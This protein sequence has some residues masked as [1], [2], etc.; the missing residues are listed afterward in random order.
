MNRLSLLLT[1]STMFLHL[2]W[3]E[4]FL[5]IFSHRQVFSN[6]CSAYRHSSSLTYCQDRVLFIC[7]SLRKYAV[8]KTLFFDH[9]LYLAGKHTDRWDWTCSYTHVRAP[10]MTAVSKK[11]DA[12]QERKVVSI[13]SAIPWCSCWQH[14]FSDFQSDKWWMT[15]TESNKTEFGLS[16][17]SVSAVEKIRQL[18]SSVFVKKADST[19]YFYRSSAGSHEE[20][21]TN[22]NITSPYSMKRNWNYWLGQI[23]GEKKPHT[24]LIKGLHAPTLFFFFFLPNSNIS[25]TQKNNVTVIYL[26]IYF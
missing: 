5:P 17:C 24:E 19:I 22:L 9:K 4:L 16:W 11:A 1:L 25:Y 3:V 6:L 10:P 18:L 20:N 23:S 8:L 26:F 2:N 13:I 12:L 7:H 21:Y 14:P 15:W